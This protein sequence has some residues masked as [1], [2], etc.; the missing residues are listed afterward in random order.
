M[1]ASGGGNS[2]L[3]SP[4]NSISNNPGP[5]LDSGGTL[6]TTFSNASSTSPSSSS[7][8]CSPFLGEEKDK[9]EKDYA[10][11]EK[12]VIKSIRDLRTDDEMCDVTFLVGISPASRVEIKANS[13]ILSLRSPYFKVSPF[14]FIFLNNIYRE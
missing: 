3:P 2:G 4:K 13:T 6:S 10:L 12:S 8:A 5:S 14:Y 11:L 7:S 1:E 9:P